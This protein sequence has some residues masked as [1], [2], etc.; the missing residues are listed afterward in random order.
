M[1]LY[2]TR[3]SWSAWRGASLLTGW[4]I[5]RADCGSAFSG[6][7]TYAWMQD[8]QPL[9]LIHPDSK[10]PFSFVGAKEVGSGA[11][12]AADAFSPLTSTGTGV[13][14]HTA[15]KMQSRLQFPGR[16]Q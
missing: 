3:D 11:V 10:Q 14:V 13:N 6:L 1:A 9:V 4:G 16:R 7:S 8:C 5:S 2:G 15:G 12:E